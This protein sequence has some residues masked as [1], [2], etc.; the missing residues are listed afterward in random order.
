MDAPI[1]IIFKTVGNTRRLAFTI[2]LAVYQRRLLPVKVMAK[3]KNKIKKPTCS[4]TIVIRVKPE[5]KALIKATAK[6]AGRSISDLGR[7]ALLKL[8]VT[9]PLSEKEIQALAPL[10][11]IRGDLVNIQNAL[12]GTSDAIKIKLFNNF[13]FMRKWLLCIEK[14]VQYL[15]NV[16]ENIYK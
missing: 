7:R 6:E 14:E 16:F 13:D 3:K 9:A 10:S 11:D 4:E 15:D 8:K 2:H 1:L 12:N 5:E